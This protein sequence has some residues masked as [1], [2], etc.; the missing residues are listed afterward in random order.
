MYLDPLFNLKPAGP[1][2]LGAILGPAPRDGYPST[3]SPWEKVE[4]GVHQI[5]PTEMIRVSLAAML[6]ISPLWWCGFAAGGVGSS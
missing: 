3:G 4:V 5:V 6:T 1:V 2:S